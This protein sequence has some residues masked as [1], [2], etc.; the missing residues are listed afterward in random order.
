MWLFTPPTVT[1]TGDCD[2]AIIKGVVAILGQLCSGKSAAEV[3]DLHVDALFQGL[4][5][6]EHLSPNWHVGVFAI[7]EKMNRQARALAGESPFTA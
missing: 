1:Y 4:H 2:T 7:G 5:L 3:E 6:E